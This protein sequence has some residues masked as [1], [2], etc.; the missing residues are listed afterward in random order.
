MAGKDHRAQ[1]RSFKK[2]TWYKG[3][4]VDE[5]SMEE[6]GRIAHQVVD[7]LVEQ[8]LLSNSDGKLMHAEV[9]QYIQQE[10]MELQDVSL[11]SQTSYY[12]QWEEKISEIAARYIP[13][14]KVPKFELCGTAEKSCKPEENC[15]KGKVKSA[16]CKPAESNK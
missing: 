9:E 7:P 8:G 16:C 15:D 13:K 1:L 11:L 6:A 4:R 2:D 5:L 12:D 14:D 10:F 3:E